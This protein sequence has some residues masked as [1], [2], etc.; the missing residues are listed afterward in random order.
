MS[1]L[2][3]C[4]G[5]PAS[6]K[7][8]YTRAAIAKAPPGTLA[9]VNR[10]DLRRMLFG[11]DYRRPDPQLEPDVTCA[12]HTLIGNFLTAGTDVIVDDTNL[13]LKHVLALEALTELT[14]THVVILDHF[15]RVPLEVCIQR[16]TTRPPGEQVGAEVITAMWNRYTQQQAGR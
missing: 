15:L 10:D 2:F 8:T 14:G 13:H 11:P 6:G 12:E 7:T 5:L 9:R 4:R 3:I 1:T 16:D